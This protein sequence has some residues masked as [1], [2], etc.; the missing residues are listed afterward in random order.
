MACE[1][2]NRFLE[3][4]AGVGWGCVSTVGSIIASKE[5]IVDVGTRHMRTPRLSIYAAG[6][7]YVRVSPDAGPGSFLSRRTIGSISFKPH[8]HHSSN[9]KVCL[10]R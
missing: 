5:D 1:K 3:E 4:G 9:R 10:E 6:A 8:R 2:S 7:L